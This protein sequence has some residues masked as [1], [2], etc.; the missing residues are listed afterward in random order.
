MLYQ[1]NKINNLPELKNMIDYS[2]RD[3]FG[4]HPIHIGIKEGFLVKKQPISSL[5]SNF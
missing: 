5:F 3:F 2:D 4:L 1:N